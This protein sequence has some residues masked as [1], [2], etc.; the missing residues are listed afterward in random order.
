ML[1]LIN[2][3]FFTAASRDSYKKNT[4]DDAN[5]TKKIAVK[6]AG[7]DNVNLE[8]ASNLRLSSQQL[9]ELQSAG[10]VDQDK[11]SDENN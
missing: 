9:A 11:D 4:K 1:D 10:D 2:N 7:N 5:K 8:H 6:T 3:I